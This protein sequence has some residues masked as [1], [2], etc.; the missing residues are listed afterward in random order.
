MFSYLQLSSMVHF[1]TIN[2]AWMDQWVR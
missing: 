1:Q 2:R